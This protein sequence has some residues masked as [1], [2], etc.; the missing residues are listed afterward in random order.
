MVKSISADLT[1][2]IQAE[3][4]TLAILVEIIR[5]DRVAYY[6]TN[7]DTPLVF[8]GIT[9]RNDIPFTLS[10]IASG[11]SL[12][13]DNVS[14]QV[15]LDGVVFTA[16][17]FKGGAYLHAETTIR[18]INFVDPTDGALIMRKGWFGSIE[19]NQQG[20]ADITVVGLLKTLEFEIGRK[21]QPSCDA[22]FGDKRCKVAVDLG[23]AHSSRNR[24]G[25]GDWTYVHNTALM[26]A[27]SL[28]NPSFEA[29]GVV[30]TSGTITGWTKVM[31]SNGRIHVSTNGAPGDASLLPALG[32][33]L[34]CGAGPEP[35]DAN[36]KGDRMVY[37]DLDLTT[38]PGTVL[39]DAGK[40]MFLYT[41]AVAHTLYLL[42]PIQLSVTIYDAND[43]V[44]GYTDTKYMTLDAPNEFRDRSLAI[45]LRPGARRARLRIHLFRNHDTIANCGA[46]DV[47][48]YWWDVTGAA[49]YSDAIHKVVRT[50]DAN[51]ENYYKNFNNGS[52]ETPGAAIAN[53][54]VTAISGWT[55]DS[56]ADYW[57]VDTTF[58]SVIAPK[59]NYYLIG[60]DDGSATQKTYTLSQTYTIVDW[61]VDLDY[62]DL[63]YIVGSLNLYGVF[64][65]AA[66]SMYVYVECLNAANGVLSSTDVIGTSAAYVTN[67]GAPITVPYAKSFTLPT[68]TRKL[69]VVLKA[70]SAVGVSAANVGFDYI[71][72]AVLNAEEQ[73]KYD[74]ILSNG[75]AGTVFNTT[76]G[77][78]TV[79]GG[80][81]WKA[82]DAVVAFD[83]VATVTSAKQFTGTTIS[84]VDGLYT[85]ALI[86]W[87]SGN[88]AGK[89]NVIRTWTSTGKV[90]KLYFG[91]VNDIQVGDR[92]MY[93]LPCNKRFTED[94]RLLFDNTINF[95]GFPHL[96]GR[97]SVTVNV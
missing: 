59:G 63:G 33:Y 13:V 86:Q 20:Y 50:F 22:D 93:I 16:D 17:D 75:A 15:A 87:L 55:R 69:K 49:P 34:L 24:Y 54:G 5:Q 90:I 92:F 14:M 3:S 72:C 41:V 53:S 9:Y 70:R 19:Y 85:T 7:H 71:R 21:Y 95:R 89:K 35:G 78:Y 83:L 38:G 28:T 4:T 68:L 97:L 96:P 32:S 6:L 73:T 12:N 2:A 23:Q 42:D 43:N 36:F 57:R 29:D 48:A 30:G 37:Q 39:I 47:R 88:N 11:S 62:V 65:D 8:E 51:D 91:E 18:K 1:T 74:P 56:S 27:F 81:V 52:F 79:D 31:D 67:A 66:S 58:M 60:G 64:H 26:S 94:C 76:P 45:P 40:V 80:L 44:L 77:T 61:G 46:D 84:G 25:M 82:T 10:A